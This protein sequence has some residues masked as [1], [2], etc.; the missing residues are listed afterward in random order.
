MDPVGGRVSCRTCM[1]G[2]QKLILSAI[3][4]ASL[5]RKRRKRSKIEENRRRKQPNDDHQAEVPHHQA[6]QV[7]SV[8]NYCPENF[9]EQLFLAVS[10]SDARSTSSN[11]RDFTD[12]HHGLVT[13]PSNSI[14]VY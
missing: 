11:R 7:D 4:I 3:F 12:V 5:F 9:I 14:S 2:R 8:G 6:K 10:R 1:L 13:N